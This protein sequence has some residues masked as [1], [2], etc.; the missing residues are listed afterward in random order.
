[1]SA[2]SV[3]ALCGGVGGAKLALGLY[4]VL[5]PDSLTLIVNTGDDFDHLGLRICPDLDT[6]LYTL[7]DLANPEAGWGRRDETWTFMKTLADLGG[8]TWFRLGDA[9]LALHVERT[10]RLKAGEP[11]S[12]IVAEVAQRFRIH[13][14]IVPMSDEAVRTRVHTREAVL[15]FQEYFVRRRCEPTVTALE[16]AGATAARIAPQALA[17]LNAADVAAIIL[18]PSNPYLSVDPI[19]ALPGMRAALKAA[20]APVV[21]VTPLVAGKA[22]KGPTAKIMAELEVP[23]SS[24]AIARHYA[25]FIDGFVLDRADATLAPAFSCS[26]L[27]ADTLMVTLADRERLARE[28]LQFAATVRREAEDQP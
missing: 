10:R 9:D 16:Y 23:L 22:I 6:T 8:E 15:A 13:A 7:A 20:P 3:V 12:R 21:A 18:C 14:A 1:V 4:R 25:D 27:V 28:V 2:S 17:A 24:A 11:L 19:L 5:P 26:L